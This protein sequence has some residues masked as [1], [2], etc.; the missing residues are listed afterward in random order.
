MLNVFIIFPAKPRV[1]ISRRIKLN[2]AREVISALRR[3][4]YLLALNSCDL[5][6]LVSNEQV[7]SMMVIQCF[8]KIALS[9]RWQQISALGLFGRLILNNPLLLS[10]PF[11]SA[12]I[13]KS[14]DVNIIRLFVIVFI[15]ELWRHSYLFRATSQ[16]LNRWSC[17]SFLLQSKQFGESFCFHSCRFVPFDKLYIR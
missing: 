4:L 12:L 1:E 8:S 10:K 6:K 16:L 5:L 7:S 3:L 15:I 11:I 2:C 9:G 13:L 14:S 17:V